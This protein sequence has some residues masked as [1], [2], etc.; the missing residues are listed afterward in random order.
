MVLWPVGELKPN[1]IW[2]LRHELLFYSLF[3]VTMLQR[4]RY[5]WLLAMWLVAPIVVSVLWPSL[6][7]PEQTTLHPVVRE[8][9]DVVFFGSGSNLQFGAGLLLG[10]LWIRGSRVVRQRLP[11]GPLLPLS[12]AIAAAALIE[13][14]SPVL[15]SGAVRFSV[16]T[17]IAA[18]VVWVGL[19]TRSTSGH[20]TSF[21]TLLGN[22]S[23]AVYLVHNAALLILLEASARVP[24]EVSAYAYLVAFVILATTAGVAVHL[25][26]EA[27]LLKRLSSRKLRAPV[28]YSGRV[29]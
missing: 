23:Y 3:A 9:L 24:I 21:A 19:V 25:L 15:G 22:A 5:P 1:V 17:L 4:R 16:W 20:M 27:P 10:A 6:Q 12:A 29:D 14:V 18:L 13:V 26:V 28:L 11:L 7:D 8:L 2:T